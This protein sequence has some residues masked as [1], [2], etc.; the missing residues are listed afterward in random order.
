MARDDMDLG[1]LALFPEVASAF[2]ALANRESV[3]T[4][5]A[6]NHDRLIGFSSSLHDE[7]FY[8]LFRTRQSRPRL[9]IIC[10]GML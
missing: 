1:M 3:Q 8:C 4:E 7:D 2:Q 6:E 10:R 9:R 5:S